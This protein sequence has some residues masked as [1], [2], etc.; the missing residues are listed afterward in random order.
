MAI[1]RTFKEAFQKGLR[2][3]EAGPDRLG[4]RRHAGRRPAAGRVARDAA[5]R[6]PHAD[7]RADLPD[8]ARASSSAPSVEAI[9]ERTADRSLVPAPDARAARG[10][11]RVAGDGGG[12]RRAT[13]SAGPMLRRMKRLGFSDRQLGRSARASP[14]TTIRARATSARHPAR[15]TRWWTPAP[16]SSPRPRRTSTRSY[17]EE[18]EARAERR[19]HGR[20][21]GQRS[22]PDRAGSRV[23]LLLRARRD[24]ASASWATGRSWSTRIPRPS[25]PTSTSRTSCTS[26]R[27]RSR[28]CS[29]SSRVE[30]PIGVVVQLGGQTPL[31]LARGLEREGRADPGHLARRDRPGGG[32]RPVRGASPASW[33]WRSR[34]AARR[35]GGGGGGGGRAGRLSGAGAA[36]PTCSAAGRWRS[37]TTTPRSRSYFA[38]AARVAPEHPVLIDSFLEDAFEAD[39][40]AHRRRHPVRD[41]RRHAAHRGRGHPLRRLGLRAAAVPHHRGAGGGDAASTPAPSPSGWAW[42]G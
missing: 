4:D 32:P 15:P 9:A 30:Q 37:C 16:A 38:R 12:R 27:S 25:P 22:Q 24:G 35:L 6:A 33:A 34:R 11:A 1:G 41:R 18:N 21:P 3:L 5:R 40:D 7:A 28:T 10:G 17:D 19:A 2:G 29:R 26:S 36:R 14:R 8:Q 31:R 20:H 39:V 23:R 42:S 13:T